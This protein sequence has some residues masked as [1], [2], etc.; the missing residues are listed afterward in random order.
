[1]EKSSRIVVIG[2]GAAGLIAARELARGGKHVTILEARDR[3]G[4]RICPLPYDDFGYAADGGAEFVHGDAPV[5][6]GLLRE[7]GLSLSPMRGTSRSMQG[8]QF[9]ES[10]VEPA[11]RAA[12]QAALQQITNDLPVSQF[13]HEHFAGPQYDALRHSIE[14]MTEGYDAA[15]PER[16]STLALSDEWMIGGAHSQGRIEGGYGAIITFL[17]AEC[18][19]HGVEIRTGTPVTAI[20]ETIDNI[21]VRARGFCETADAA[22]LTVPLPLLTTIELPVAERQKLA[23]VGEIGFGNV[24]KI[25]LRFEKAWWADLRRE[26]A[27]LTF[28][29]SDAKIPVWWTQNPLSVPVLTGWFGGPRTK[30]LAHLSENQLVEA[31]LAS[32]SDIFGVDIEEFAGKPVFARAINWANDPF[33]RGAYSYATPTSRAAHTQLSQEVTRKIHFAGE[34]FYEGRDMGTVEAALASGLQIGWTVLRPESP[35]KA[36][37]LGTANNI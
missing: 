10:A 31:G 7:A 14:G 12:L 35:M 21:V 37:D 25:L 11:H 6:R 19:R 18:L 30:E 20:E 32:L 23:A 1:M 29:H 22:I 24:I 33:S 28:V 3:C 5:T 17:V 8:G 16:A 36:H 2:A 4:G 34:A 26:L 27:D 9:T 13:L 15:D